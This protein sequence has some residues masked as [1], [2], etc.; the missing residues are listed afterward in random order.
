MFIIIENVING[1]G[2]VEGKDTGTSLWQC[3]VVDEILSLLIV[4]ITGMKDTA[5]IRKVVFGDDG[6]F[7]F[8][9]P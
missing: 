2:V 3:G 5:F 6:I 4:L 7:F 8:D 1:L 9:F